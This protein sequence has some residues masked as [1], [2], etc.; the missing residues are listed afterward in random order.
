MFNEKETVLDYVRREGPVLPIQ[1]AKK[2]N[3]NTMFA[4]AILSELIANKLIRITS[5]KI[6]GSPIYYVHGQEERL[7]ILYDHLPGKEKEAYN[8]LKNNKI[9]LDELQEPS[10]RFALSQIKDFAMPFN[11]NVKE[12][13]I[14]CWRWHLVSEEEGT[15]LV[16]EL[17]QEKKEEPK[18][19]IIEESN[20]I[21][22]IQVQIQEKPIIKKEEKIKKPKLE[23][24]SRFFENVYNYLEKEVIKKGKEIDIITKV[25]SVLG[26][27]NFLI[28]AKD[29]KVISEKDLVFAYNDGSLRK[30][31]VI[32]LSKGKLSK[33][34]E[35][36]INEKLKGYL[37]FKNIE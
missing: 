1:V 9:L 2:I 36:Y 32:L 34:A 28:K 33:K 31:P 26:E 37:V 12:K 5:A 16:N 35:K 11:V 17:F 29:N 20:I 6:G 19:G 25:P 23:E 21:K 22:D 18:S 13:N 30:I 27:L 4:G 8:L 10:I 7:Y 15:R 24:K 14:N 3:G